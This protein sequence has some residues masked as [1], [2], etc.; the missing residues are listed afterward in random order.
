MIALLQFPGE[1][2]SEIILKIGQSF[3]NLYVDFCGYYF[4]ANP[5]IHSEC[6]HFFLSFDLSASVAWAG[7]W[8]L[9]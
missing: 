5:V 3:T 8:K 1:F 4:L 2:D 9:E 6:K 7:T